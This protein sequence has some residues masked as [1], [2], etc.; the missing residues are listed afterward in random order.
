M[1]INLITTKLRE[2]FM[3]F[4]LH[5]EWIVLKLATRCLMKVK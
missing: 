3:R 2:I 5:I 1:K 4:Y